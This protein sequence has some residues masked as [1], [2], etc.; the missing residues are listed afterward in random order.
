MKLDCK[1]Y[2]EEKKNKAKQISEQYLQET[3]NKPE[4]YIFNKNSDR[5]NETYVKSKVKH[6]LESGIQP[7][8]INDEVY[9]GTM[10]YISPYSTSIC[11]V[12]K[13][14]DFEKELDKLYGMDD[15]R[16]I[17][18]EYLRTDPHKVCTPAGIVNLLK[19]KCNYELKGKTAVII[20]RGNIIGKP[21]AQLLLDEDA[22]VIIAHSKTPEHN[23]KKLCQQADI[24]FVGVGIPSFLD[25]T[26][27]NNSGK[28]VVIDFGINRD[29]EGK[30]CGD[31]NEES[32]KDKVLYYTGTPG[33]T[34]L[35]T[36]AQLIDNI[37]EYYKTRLTIMNS[38]DF[39]KYF[40]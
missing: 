1:S 10:E 6:C 20:N 9:N 37:T 7:I 30:L 29:N 4:I 27:L 18:I 26:Y 19:E 17:D 3:G 31:I 21:L 25:D 39:K 16:L 11:L 24:I 13:C 36:V 38:C 33:G 23:L 34:G 40:N 2:L 22:T 5:A 15:P 12:Q 32:I 8:V 35:T 14:E 28:Q